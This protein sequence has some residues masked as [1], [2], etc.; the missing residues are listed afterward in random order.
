MAR[1]RYNNP[2]KVKSVH[3]FVSSNY[4]KKI[5]N[6]RKKMERKIGRPIGMPK[7]TEYLLN[8]RRYV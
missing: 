3:I 2:F 6:E 1:L 7:Y 4:Y 8:R 5:E